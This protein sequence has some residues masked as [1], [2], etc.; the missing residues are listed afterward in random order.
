MQKCGKFNT[1]VIKKSLNFLGKKTKF[2]IIAV[3]G[4]KGKKKYMGL[5][6]RLSTMLTFKLYDI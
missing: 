1:M 5:Y 4:K 6:D 2:T 3:K